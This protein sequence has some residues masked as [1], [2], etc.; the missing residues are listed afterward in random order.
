MDP[1]E[2]RTQIL[3]EHAVLRRRLL[4]VQQLAERALRRAEVDPLELRAEA[5]ALA[6]VFSDHLAMEDAQLAPLLATLDAWGPVR[7]ERMNGEHAVQRRM[8]SE[9]LQAVWHQEPSALCVCLDAFVKALLVDMA[10]EEADTLHPDLLR[11]D[12]IGIDVCSG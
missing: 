7:L 6:S 10:S 5:L 2:V 3:Q 12:A 9:L 11:D 1:S 4:H 8:I